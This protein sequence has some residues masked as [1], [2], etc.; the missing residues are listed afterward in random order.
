MHNVD[1]SNQ[2]MLLEQLLVPYSERS[3]EQL[4]ASSMVSSMEKLKEPE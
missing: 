2:L 3:K 4:K 1:K